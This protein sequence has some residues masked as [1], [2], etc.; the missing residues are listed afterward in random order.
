MLEEDFLLELLVVLAGEG[1]RTE[2]TMG[3]LEGLLR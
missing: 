1:D 2:S 3:F